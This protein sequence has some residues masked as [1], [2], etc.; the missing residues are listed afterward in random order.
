MAEYIIKTNAPF[1]NGNQYEF[2]SLEREYRKICDQIHSCSPYHVVEMTRYGES[3]LNEI[4][5]GLTESQNKYLDALKRAGAPIMPKGSYGRNQKFNF[6]KFENMVKVAVQNI[7]GF[8]FSQVRIEK[9][10]GIWF[11]Y[12][13]NEMIEYCKKFHKT[14]W[15]N[16]PF[17]ESKLQQIGYY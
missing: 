8:T 4:Y 7:Y 9:A 5:D 10:D 1:E 6:D 15:E 17:F 2:G 12:M 14:D 13:E 16:K 3:L 11:A